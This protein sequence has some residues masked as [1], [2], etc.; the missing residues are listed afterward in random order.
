VGRPTATAPTTPPTSRSERDFLKTFLL[1]TKEF[2][3]RRDSP[4]FFGRRGLD[5]ALLPRLVEK[6]HRDGLRV[7]TH[8]E[9]PA[10]FH[11]AVAAGVDE[12]AHLPGYVVPRSRQPAGYLIS[13]QDA[14][15][16]GRRGMVV[17][18]T[19]SLA[20]QREK[21]PE[22]LKAIQDLQVRN[23]RLL[24]R[25]GVPISL[26]SDDSSLT[27]RTE[28]LYL[29]AVG[30]FDNRTLLRLWCETTPRAI[31]PGRRIGRLQPGFEASFLVLAG[32]P[33]AEFSNVTRIRMRF[34][35][36]SPILL[37]NTRS[38]MPAGTAEP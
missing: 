12:V 7:T 5:P 30:A 31:F 21:D 6:A 34:K 11:H 9:T 2:E 8:V 10:D 19:S 13:E 23:L 36:G 24:Q 25:Y 18:T 27:A 15:L 4:E 1:Y 28:A 17:V 33:V 22:R 35:Q 16:A 37:D 38:A 20:Q 14:R 26:G 3:R 32:D 29:Q